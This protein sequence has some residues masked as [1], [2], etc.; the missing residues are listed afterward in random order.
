MINPNNLVFIPG[1]KLFDRA[2]RDGII[3]GIHDSAFDMTFFT[4]DFL[5][6]P[7]KRKNLYLNSVMLMMGGRFRERMMGHIPRFLVPILIRPDIL[8]F[9]DRHTRVTEML[10]RLFQL[11]IRIR[12]KIINIYH[13]KLK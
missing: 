2:C 3:D 5:T 6:F 13:S 1:T 9:F 12:K 10:V 7:W 8:D 4:F 11:A